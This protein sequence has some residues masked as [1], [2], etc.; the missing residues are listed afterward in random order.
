MM[1]TNYNP[2]VLTC[3]ANLSN[4]EVFTP[5]SLVNDM[6]DLLPASLW[7]NPNAT[8]LDPVCKSGVFLREIAKR[9]DHGLESQI[10]DRQKRI[11]HIFT[12][13]VFGIAITELTSLLS[14]RSVYCS[15]YANSKYS[16][17][18]SFT[19]EQGN[20]R[21]ERLAHTWQNGNCKFCGASQEVYDRD[22]SLETYAYPFLH[23]EKPEELFTMKFDVI[24]G[25]PPYQLN[26]GGFGKSAI[27]LYNRFVEQAKKIQPTYLVMIIPS[28]WF[29]GGRG[30]DD[31]R[32]EM[33][34]DEQ[35]RKIVDYEDSSEVFPG[36]S[37][38]GGVCYFLWQKGSRGLTEIVN[39]SNPE[40]STFRSLKEFPK[41][42]RSNESIEIMRKISSF[43]ETTME[44]VVS[45]YRPFGLRTYIK[46]MTQGDIRLFWLG[47]IGPYQ[48]KEITVGVEMIDKWKVVS[49]RSGHEHGGNP[50]IHGQRR[51]LSKIEVLQPGVICTETYLVIGSYDSELEARNLVNY[52]KTKFFRFLLSQLMFSHSITKET[53]AF[54]PSLDMKLLWT[55]EK[56]YAKYGLS[57]EEINFIE[58]MIRPMNLNQNQEDDE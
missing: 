5:P 40:K 28:R 24:V 57:E 9:L 38:A 22:D 35:I 47:G 12:K 6:L 21:Y 7:R 27:P 13:Q 58:S 11:D 1:L 56:L 3:L 55:D 20:I 17:C 49:S 39:D 19:T 14:R 16:V 33:L 54:V 52:M 34:G 51:V 29:G 23:T 45:S 4:D 44:N 37:I 48:R 2:D 30:L 25:N 31:F 8:F 53:Y 50:G 36:V 32:N 18:E 41:F 42:I 43:K 15:K 26:D 46:P 10:P